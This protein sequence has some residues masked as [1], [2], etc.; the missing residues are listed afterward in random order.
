M[1]KN[2]SERLKNLRK[3]TGKTQGEISQILGIQRSSYGEYERG[4]NRPTAETLFKISN[5]YGVTVDYLAGMTQ[6][7]E[8]EPV[9]SKDVYNHLELFIGWL[10]ANDEHHYKGAPLTGRSTNR[11]SDYNTKLP[12]NAWKTFAG[13]CL[14]IPP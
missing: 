9:I 14:A 13:C 10:R 6:R 5:L 1:N 8:P 11:I 4:I 2:F 12:A 7:R 3:E